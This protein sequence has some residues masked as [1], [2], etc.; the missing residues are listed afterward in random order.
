MDTA[1]ME[2]A[3]GIRSA[4][5]RAARKRDAIYTTEKHTAVMTMNA[6]TA[7][8]PARIT[9]AARREAAIITESAATEDDDQLIQPAHAAG[10][11]VKKQGAEESLVWAFSHLLFLM[12]GFTL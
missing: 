7:T 2:P 3:T 10:C 1:G 12:P 9:R 11:S 6:A 4:Q 5:K 8:G